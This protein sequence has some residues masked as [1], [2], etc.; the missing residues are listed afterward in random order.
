M[1]RGWGPKHRK[2]D[3]Q[4]DMEQSFKEAK[5]ALSQVA[6]LAHLLSEPE[7]SLAVDASDHHVG[8]VLQQKC[9]AGWQPLAFVSRKLNA[10]ET[11]YSTLDRELLPCVAAI[12]HFPC[13]VEGGAFTL[14]TDHK[15]LTYLLAKQADAWSD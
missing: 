6:I 4:P 14:Y 10:A 13:L 11:K 1:P 7:L 2:L 3:W 9:A 12:R 15:P 5:V 8:G